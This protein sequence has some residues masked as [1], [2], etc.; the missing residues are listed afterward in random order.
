M[1]TSSGPIPIEDIK[2][3]E[4]VLAQDVETGELGLRPVL[5][6]TI[7]PELPLVEITSGGE[8]IRCTYGHLFWVSGG[9]WKM[10][11]ELE[12]GQWLH[13]TRG[14]VVIDNVEK[15]GKASCHNLIVAEF[16]TYFITDQAFLVHDIN[17]RGP[18]MATVP[19]LIDEAGDVVSMSP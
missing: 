2:V 12:A 17:V 19:G 15:K 4:I 14:P 3:G 11:K 13:T 9:G 7:G 10:A 1:S 16:N 18:T 8:T 5:A 6:T